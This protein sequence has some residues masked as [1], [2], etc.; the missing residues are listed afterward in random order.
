MI[1]HRKPSATPFGQALSGLE[2]IETSSDGHIAARVRGRSPATIAFRTPESIAEYASA[3]ELGAQVGQAVSRATKAAL[4]QRWHL[5]T[6]ST[7]LRLSDEPA[8][9]ADRRRF[10]SEQAN[11]NACGLSPNEVVDVATTALIEWDVNVMLDSEALESIDPHHFCSEVNAAIRAT[12]R[13]YEAQIYDLKRKYFGQI[14]PPR[15][16]L[17]SRKRRR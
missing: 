2:V 5:I 7:R 3:T 11:L 12:H 1:P 16:E 17:S 4:E 13:D 9:D 8:A 15:K 10:H 14:G 6:R